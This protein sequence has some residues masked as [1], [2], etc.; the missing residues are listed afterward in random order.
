MTFVLTVPHP[1][2][3]S[4]DVVTQ[5]EIAIAVGLQAGNTL[6]LLNDLDAERRCTFDTHTT[7]R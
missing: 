2:S 4:V 7:V 5:V 6:I 1:A 3:A